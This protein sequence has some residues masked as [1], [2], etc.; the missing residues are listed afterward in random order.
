MFCRKCGN[1]V[2]DGSDSCPRCGNES[3]SEKIPPIFSKTKQAGA[4]SIKP[5]LFTLPFWGGVVCLGAALGAIGAKAVLPGLAVFTIG[6]VSVIFAYVYSLVCLHRAWSV[7]HDYN[8]RTTPGKAVGYLF[9]PF[10]SIYWVFVAFRGLAQ[11]ANEFSRQTGSRARISENLSLAAAISILIPYVNILATPVIISVL[12]NQWANFHNSFP[13]AEDVSF[14]VDL[15]HVQKKYTAAIVACLLVTVGLTV[16]YAA[17]G[18]IPK[19]ADFKKT[20]GPVSDMQSEC[21]MIRNAEEAYRAAHGRYLQTLHPETDLR[22][23]GISK[24]ST[25]AIVLSDGSFY[26]ISM[27]SH[28]TSRKLRY[29]STEGKVQIE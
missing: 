20:G 10:F 29:N 21:E 3:L 13:K 8:A 14:G 9:I 19:F 26:I 28:K 17:S 12:I 27:E 11:D 23:Y 5:R 25:S 4:K 2:E 22:K 6:F 16:L 18:G 7:L 24:L 1:T 15:H